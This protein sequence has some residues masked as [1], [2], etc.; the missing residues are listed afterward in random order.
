MHELAVTENI[1]NLAL[2][3]AEAGGA[4]QITDVYLVIGQL[5]SIVD[6]SVR[7]YWDFINV[8]TIAAGSRLHFRRIPAMLQC[9]ACGRRYPPDGSELACP[10]CGGADVQVI[11]GEE[12]YLEAIDVEG[13]TTD[14][15]TDSRGGKHSERQ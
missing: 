1:L 8:G 14:A 6:D 5:S 12:F 13:A 7:F 10:D 9:R 15:E 2:Q 11:A 3:H 4:Q